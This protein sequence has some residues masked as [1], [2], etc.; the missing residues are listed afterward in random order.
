MV[1]GL[2]RA[3]ILEAVQKT[4]SISGAA[5]EL[6][7]SSKA[8]WERLRVTEKR[9][10]RQLVIRQKGGASGGSSRLSDEARQLLATFNELHEKIVSSDDQLFEQT[11][12]SLFKTTP[13]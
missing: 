8:V 4:G 5:R 11:V 3:R 2:G 9:L 7:M 13:S 1:F 10:G 12:A 6:G